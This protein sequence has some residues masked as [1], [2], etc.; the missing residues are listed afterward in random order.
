[1]VFRAAAPAVAARIA[2]PVDLVA[3][4]LL[5]GG[6]L[7]LLAGTYRSL[8]A[9]V[10]NGTLAAMAGFVVAGLAVGHLLGGPAADHRIVLAIAT[11]SRHPAIALTV[12]KVNFP[13]EPN[14]GATILLYLLVN[15]I[16]GIPYQKWQQRRAAA[17]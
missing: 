2:K 15:A 5:L 10:G 12:A 14:L 6:V 4:V 16:V 9:L 1:M 11:A 7:A 17:T 3:K 13:D 8:L